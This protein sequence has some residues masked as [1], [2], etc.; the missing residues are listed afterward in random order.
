MIMEPHEVVAIHQPNFFPWLGYFNKIARCAL[1]VFLDDVAYPK[2]GKSMG[3]FLNRVKILKN[4]EPRWITCPVIREH[5]RQRIRNIR[6]RPGEPWKSAMMRCL[7]FNYKKAPHFEE[8][9]R[10]IGTILEHEE[11]ELSRFNRASIGELCRRLHIE[12][13]FLLQS[14]LETERQG[15]D[16]LIEIVRRAGGTSYLCGGGANGYQEDEKFHS[17]GIGLIYQN[18]CHPAYLQAGKG[19]HPGLSIIDALMFCG[20]DEVEKIVK[21]GD[22]SGNPGDGGGSKNRQCETDHR[23]SRHGTHCT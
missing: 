20:F 13:P 3:S 11:E 17:A 9:F 15:T 14:K 18:F 6:I 2:S 23:G 5:G 4:G 22:F 21:Y 8:I 16:L 10:C 12:T 19:F 1:F 7:E